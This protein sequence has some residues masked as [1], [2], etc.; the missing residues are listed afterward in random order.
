MKNAYIAAFTADL[1]QKQRIAGKTALAIPL[2]HPLFARKGAAISPYFPFAKPRK[3]SRQLSVLAL[4][5]A[6]PHFFPEKISDK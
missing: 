5:R 1:A 2:S 3:K 4:R 6:Q